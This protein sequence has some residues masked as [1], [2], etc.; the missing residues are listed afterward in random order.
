MS[1]ERDP[2]TC[3]HCALMETI[4][5][6]YGEDK[7]PVHPGSP[8]GRYGEIMHALAQMAGEAVAVMVL[9]RPPSISAAEGADAI[10]GSLAR[11]TEDVMAR[12]EYVVDRRTGLQ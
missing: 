12:L 3:L 4:E 10:Q 1:N 8:V 5:R 11:F 7:W 2:K 9:A 6:Y